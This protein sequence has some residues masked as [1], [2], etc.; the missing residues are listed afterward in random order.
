M[1]FPILLLS[2]AKYAVNFTFLGSAIFTFGASLLGIPPN[3]VG[4]ATAKLISFPFLPLLTYACPPEISPPPFALG[5]Q[6]SFECNDADSFR[7]DDL[8]Q[9]VDD[10]DTFKDG[11]LIAVGKVIPTAVAPPNSEVFPA[12]VTTFFLFILLQLTAPILIGIGL[13]FFEAFGPIASIAASLAFVFT[14]LA[15]GQSWKQIMNRE[16]PNEA[17]ASHPTALLSVSPSNAGLT[18]LP[19]DFKFKL[20]DNKV[21]YFAKTFLTIEDK[22]DFRFNVYDSTP[23][24]IDFGDDKHIILEAN[25]HYGFK[26]TPKT[27]PIV[28]NN[29][30][31]TDN[32]APNIIP[33][34]VGPPFFLLSSLKQDQYATWIATDNGYMIHQPNIFDLTK[35]QTEFRDLKT[36]DAFIGPF[37]AAFD[38]D[39][40][41]EFFTAPDNQA[42]LKYFM[43]VENK[44]RITELV[45]NTTGTQ[46]LVVADV[47]LAEDVFDPKT[48]KIIT[49]SKDGNVLTS[50]NLRN[51]TTMS[52][53]EMQASRPGDNLNA[54]F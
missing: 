51:E 48:K 30:K 9:V 46:E 36:N 15:T 32:C 3:T 40:T 11:T 29:T 37:V 26:V 16:F 27:E 45:T 38:P 20:G 24:V 31:V 5:G 35:V 34:Y 17:I 23:P 53:E 18:D 54:F 2:I 39:N 6:T 47:I 50:Q 44:K 41:V 1:A 4:F 42:T 12:V 28:F 10:T 49:V 52:P 21:T 14:L 7:F 25:A 8:T 43:N 13:S 19:T 22:A 33:E